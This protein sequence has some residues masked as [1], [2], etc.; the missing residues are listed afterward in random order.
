MQDKNGISIA[1]PNAASFTGFVAIPTIVFF[2]LLSVGYGLLLLGYVN[3]ILAS[4]L[5]GLIGAA[6]AYGMFT[7]VHEAS[8]GN[9]AGGVKKM[10][11]LESTLGWLA[12]FTLFFPY[13]AFVVIHLQHHAHTNDP[14][15]DPDGYVKG[16]GFWSI[17]IRC[18]TLI[19]HYYGEALGKKSKQNISMMKTRTAT[20]LYIIIHL[21]LLVSVIAMGFWKVYFHVLL[22]PALFAAPF[23]GF[24]FDWLPHYPHDNMGKY[25][26]TRILT[27]PGMQWVALYQ[28]FHLIHHLYPRVPFYKYI[29]KFR[30]IEEMLRE[31]KSP[32]EGFP[33]SDAS[34]MRAA[35]TYIDI[36]KGETWHYA[37]RIEEIKALTHDSAA[38]T[39]KNLEN[40]PFRFKAGQYLVLSKKVNNRKVSRCY[41]ICSNPFSGVLTVGVKRVKGGR[42]SNALLDELEAGQRLEVAGPFGNFEFQETSLDQTCVFI[43]GGSG[44]TPM[45][46][47]IQY[48][49]EKGY[50]DLYLLY[51]C[52]SEEDV[53]FQ[54]E[55]SSLAKQ[56]STQ[57]ALDIN[58]GILHEEVQQNYL[59][60]KNREGHYYICGP[61]LMMDASMRTLES[62]GINSSN[63]F[64]EQ[65]AQKSKALTG[66]LHTIAI[67]GE[68]YE[69]YS[70]ETLLEAALRQNQSIPY[71]CT[72]GQCGTCKVKVNQGKVLWLDQEQ[73][74][75]LDTEKENGYVLTCMC[76][77]DSPFVELEF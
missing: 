70:S 36:A 33:S 8:H 41:S 23:L 15:H 71:A 20:I 21:T 43:A 26:N 54:D 63:I 32:I 72:M 24:F 45:L 59:A 4:W 53:M 69:A 42:L 2:V 17:F 9:I 50:R 68:R 16:E 13:A 40:L 52:R 6:L 60:Q 64:I 58:Y 77:A 29:H 7:V 27:I 56:Y 35:N 65:F 48:A 34:L 39:F 22:M 25:H 30:S 61:Q 38:I 11:K 14:E 62:M 55:L 31:K 75:L 3:Q 5:C 73:D 66:E 47:M 44:I 37:L 19:G 57:F 46:S 10:E 76:K 1:S 74:A 12:S 18:V 49:L 67:N 51:A 28:N